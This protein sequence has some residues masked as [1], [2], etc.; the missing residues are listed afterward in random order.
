MKH[1]KLFVIGLSVF[2]IV[3]GC[4][5]GGGSN[6]NS[7]SPTTHEVAFRVT[8][9]GSICDLWDFTITYEVRGIVD[10]YTINNFTCSELP[11][12]YSQPITGVPDNTVVDLEISYDN[13]WNTSDNGTIRGEILVDG[14]VRKTIDVTVDSHTTKTSESASG[15]INNNGTI[16]VD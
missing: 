7:S 14:T 4:G 16:G 6:S 15:T 2:F 10:K 8:S 11:W 9:T 5:G 12:T 3:Y 1:L 13:P